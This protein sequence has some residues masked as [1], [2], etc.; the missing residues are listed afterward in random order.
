VVR[1]QLIAGNE[2]GIQ[3]RRPPSCFIDD[4][5]FHPYFAWPN[6]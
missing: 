1:L 6:W 5:A 2:D 3:G 4:T